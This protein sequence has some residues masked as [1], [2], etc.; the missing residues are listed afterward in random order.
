MRF[1]VIA[2]Y[3]AIRSAL[4]TW[5]F[6]L[7]NN[8]QYPSA[9][10]SNH[11]QNFIA[12]GSKENHVI[13]VETRFVSKSHSHKRSIESTK[14]LEDVLGTF[15]ECLWDVLWRSVLFGQSRIT[16]SIRNN[17]R[18]CFQRHNERYTNISRVK[19]NASTSSTLLSF[20][21]ARFV[22]VNDIAFR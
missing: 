13:F 2:R 7:Y 17:K 12:L 15:S 22:G 5:E 11:E 3:C 16:N 6:V 18:H 14:S 10:Y 21:E 9:F 1:K 8:A 4:C 19:R 20:V